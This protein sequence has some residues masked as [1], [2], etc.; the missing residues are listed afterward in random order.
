[1]N[2]NTRQKLLCGFVALTSGLVLAGA[3]F[4]KSCYTPNPA[5]NCN[6]DQHLPCT[7][8]PQPDC[9][10]ANGNVSNTCAVLSPNGIVDAS[11]IYPQMTCTYTGTTT[12]TCVHHVQ[13]C[14][15]QETISCTNGTNGTCTNSQTF[16]TMSAAVAFK[17]QVGNGSISSG[18][19]TFTVSYTLT[20]YR[21]DTTMINPPAPI[22]QGSLD[23]YN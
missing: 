22:G 14:E 6:T 3:A 2:K 10:G 16:S 21:C 13:P 23:W 12:D 15:D 19:G 5:P 9:G 11:F 17:N 18:G 4:A 20:L 8:S 7:N 1:M